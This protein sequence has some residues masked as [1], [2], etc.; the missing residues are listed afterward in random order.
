MLIEW[1]LDLLEEAIDQA[2]SHSQAVETALAASACVLCTVLQDDLNRGLE[3][4]ELTLIHIWKLVTELTT[5]MSSSQA[6]IYD[7]LKARRPHQKLSIVAETILTIA[8]LFPN[9]EDIRTDNST[10]RDKFLADA[11]A[12]REALQEHSVVLNFKTPWKSS[13]SQ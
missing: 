7:I 9:L 13:S 4:D 10:L 8:R 1:T 12:L 11:S 2:Y 3:V 6:I 5:Y